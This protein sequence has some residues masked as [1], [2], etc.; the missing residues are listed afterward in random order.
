MWVRAG[1]GG[2]AGPTV[3]CPDGWTRINRVVEVPSA[4]VWWTIFVR[5]GIRVSG[6]LGRSSSRK[7]AS[8]TV[9]VRG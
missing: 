8:S 7:G 5:F 9:V 6:L 1:G 3:T 4:V 2:S